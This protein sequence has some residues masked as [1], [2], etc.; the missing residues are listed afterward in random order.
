MVKYDLIRSNAVFG[1]LI[2]MFV[3]I[4]I[5][6]FLV[7]PE[8]RE[9]ILPPYVVSYEKTVFDVAPGN[10]EAGSTVEGV[11]PI[12]LNDVTLDNTLQATELDVIRDASF[13][14]SLFTNEVYDFGFSID[15]DNVHSAGLSFVV[16]DLSGDGKI[17]VYLNGRSVLARTVGLGNQVIVNFPRDYIKDGAN[18]IEITAGSPGI[19]FWQKN[20]VTLL[21]LKLFTEEYNTGKASANQV[22]SLTASEVAN[23]RQATL[24]AYLVPTGNPAN[25]DLKLNGVRL[26]KATPPQ[27]LEL[28]V[29]VTALTQ[30]ANIVEWSIEQGG[31]YNIRF[32]NILI[33]TIKVSGKTSTYFFS[34]SNPDWL[35]VSTGSYDCTLALIRDS[36]DDTV[37]VE[38][39]TKVDK[40]TFA[41]NEISI[42]VCE[43]LREARN[44]IKFS[45]DDEL[46]LERATLIIKNK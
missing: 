34:I 28:S 36:G 30:G 29:P 8:V 18:R 20:A 44:E 22:F 12:S 10:L 13:S 14:T 21:D 37:V 45:A 9:E 1:L 46:D 25:I 27:S 3:S 41:T 26:L 35:K 19:K 31:K 7:A 43:Q 42:D 23:A 5:F 24:K 4:L 17:N 40:Y 2:M 33:D 39:N 6:I 32:A 15:A 11:K 16:Y 38:L